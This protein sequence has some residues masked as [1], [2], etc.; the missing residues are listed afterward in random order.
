MVVES[1]P[2]TDASLGLVYRLNIL[3]SKVDFAAIGGRYEEWNNILDA[4]YRNLLYKEEMEIVKDEEG[5]ILK[6]ELSVKDTKVYRHL[7][8]QIAKAKRNYYG[9]RTNSN[10]AKARGIWYHS[11]QKKDIWLR[12]LMMTLKLYL[13]VN[14]KKPGQALFGGFGKK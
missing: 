6:V 14:E 8:L 11:I 12:K 5:K 9:A 4:I 1:S 7:S 13:K 10:R 2:S 3:W